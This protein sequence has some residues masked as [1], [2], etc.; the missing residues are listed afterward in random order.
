M[1]LSLPST[2]LFKM[3]TSNGTF[4]AA[5]IYSH[6]GCLI[7]SRNSLPFASTCVHPQLFGARGPHLFSFLCCSIMCLYVLSSMLWCSLRFPHKKRCSVRLYPPVFLGRMSYLRYLCLFA[8]SGVQH[9]L[10][11]IFVLFSS[12]CVPYV[13]SFSGLSFLAHLAKGNVS[14]CHHV[15]R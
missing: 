1:F 14:F 7:R 12:S 4:I 10:C 5:Y 6:G 15:V 2:I 11:Y 13:A 9:I 8:Y 3:A